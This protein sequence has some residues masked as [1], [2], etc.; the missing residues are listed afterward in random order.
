MHKIMKIVGSTTGNDLCHVI[1]QAFPC[2][3]SQ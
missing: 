1:F 2:L 3:F